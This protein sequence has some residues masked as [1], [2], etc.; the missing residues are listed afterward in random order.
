MLE[1]IGTEQISARDVFVLD[2]EVPEASPA[3][4]RPTSPRFVCLLAW[5]ARHVPPTVIGSF[6]RQLLDAGAVWVACWGPDC[7]RVHDI[8][9]EEFAVWPG[10]KSEGVVMTTWHADEPLAE[11]IAF[12]LLNLK[13]DDE[14]SEGCA[15]LIGIAIGES[16]W[17][18]E[19]RA[20]YRAPGAY[21]NRALEEDDRDDAV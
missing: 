11:A 12:T 2:L 6:A 21:L 17:A 5:D 3:D 16:R 14:Y 7:E 9:D 13:P 15:S 18:E 8:I 1:K 4:L 19:M 10:R 20:A